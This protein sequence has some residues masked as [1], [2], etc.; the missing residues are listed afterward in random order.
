MR[1]RSLF[2]LI[3]FLVIGSALLFSGLSCSKRKSGGNI[4]SNVSAPEVKERS[5]KS[6]P[7]SKEGVSEEMRGTLEIQVLGFED[8]GRIPTKY[9]CDGPDVA[10]GIKW[11]SPPEGT[12]SFV[13]IVSDPDAPMGTFYH[14]VIYDIPPSI[15]SLSEGFSVDDLR[16]LGAKVGQN[17]FGKLGYNGP[18]PPPG[19]PHRYYFTIYALDVRTIG[20]PEGADAGK[21]LSAIKGHILGQASYMGVYGR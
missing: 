17:D 13:L 19:K 14:L 4:K 1:M 18:C 16:E 6:D 3:I 8:G 20:L 9:T 7:A 5:L 15:A 12:K 21:V 2:K 11:T 10:P